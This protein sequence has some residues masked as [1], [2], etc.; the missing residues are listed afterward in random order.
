[1]PWL[2]TI[3]QLTDSGQV[4]YLLLLLF[5]M[6]AHFQL[7]PRLP[8]VDPRSHLFRFHFSYNIRLWHYGPHASS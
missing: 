1:M 7:G 3:R 5:I 6:L 2:V 8:F 4:W